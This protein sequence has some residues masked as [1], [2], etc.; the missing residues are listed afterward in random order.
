PE[1]VGE[2]GVGWL[3]NAQRDCLQTWRELPAR[4][5][6]FDPADSDRG[7]FLGIGRDFYHLALMDLFGLMEVQHMSRP[8]YPWRPAA[9]MHVPFGDTTFT[10]LAREVFGAAGDE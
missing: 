8:V 5:H 7:Y 1:M 4:G 2:R 3:S 10:L 9:L 6:R